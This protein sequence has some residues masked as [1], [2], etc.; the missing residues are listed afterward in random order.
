MKNTALGRALGKNSRTIR[1]LSAQNNFDQNVSTVEPL[2]DKHFSD[3]VLSSSEL[4]QLK[5]IAV[6]C[7]YTDGIAVYQARRVFLIGKVAEKAVFIV[8]DQSTYPQTLF[9]Q[10]L[11]LFQYFV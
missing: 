7:P 1:S 4:N 6:L 9:L 3:S 10:L 8:N 11:K 2:L 5:Q